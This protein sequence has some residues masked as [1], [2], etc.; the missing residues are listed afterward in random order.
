MQNASDQL[1]QFTNNLD[2]VGMTAKQATATKQA[3]EG[4]TALQTDASASKAL[5]D[6]IMNSISGTDATIS[7]KLSNLNVISIPMDANLSFNSGFDNGQAIATYNGNQLYLAVYGNCRQAVK[8]DCNDASLQR[9]VTAYLMA[10]EQDCNTVQN[11]LAQ[12]KKQLAAGIRQSAAMLDLARVQNHQDLNS[13]DAAACL[14]NVTAAITD[15]AACGA[16][17][18]KCLDNGQFIDVTTGKPFTGVVNFY[19]LAQQL[20]F[21]TTTDVANQKLSQIPANKTFVANFVKRMKPFAADA[22]TKC[23]DI[24]DQVW[25]DYLDKAM[26]SIFY[27][28]QDKV[29]EI[30]SGCMDFVAACYTQG[31]Q[32]LSAAAQSL[33]T[34]AISAQPGMIV[35]TAEMCKNYIAACDK[36]FQGT[37]ADGVVAAY[38]AN[39]KN[40]DLNDAC[41]AI[42]QKCFTDF[43][44]SDFSN[45]YTP[46]SGL[47]TK[48]GTAWDWF[49]FDA[50]EYG[51]NGWQLQTTGISQ[52][53]QQLLADSACNP[54]AQDVFGGFT[55]YI[56]T[57]GTFIY[58]SGA[59]SGD[60]TTWTSSHKTIAYTGVASETYY[61]TLNMLQNGC[62]NLQGKFVVRQ[63]SAMVDRYNI[64]PDAD[65]ICTVHFD[66][67]GYPYITL[68]PAYQIGA[69]TG[70]TPG[71]ENMCP[72]NY[73]ADVDTKSWGACLCWENGGRRSID[74]TQ[75]SCVP[76]TWDASKVSRYIIPSTNTDIS[77]ANKVCPAKSDNE[78]NNRANATNCDPADRAALMYNGQDTFRAIPNASLN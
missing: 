41:R 19:Q 46:N 22:L 13:A 14:D 20:V 2:V 68:V 34:D 61:K 37:M 15:E 9:A 63:D 44:S 28:Q 67:T 53:A 18:H 39:Q 64:Q 38:V 32:S 24:A 33:I 57:D 71:V 16:N 4:E 10:V 56:N 3:S 76:G 66:T 36:M 8:P 48:A 43:G 11:A 47:V 26:L 72:Q 23:T 74:G 70:G 5:L 65:D 35:A 58:G 69:G 31:T 78:A 62:N 60:W 7:G 21:D 40:K 45:F 59:P 54:I 1:T 75:V 27:A 77:I 12:T 52:C 49:T 25:A 55:K 73:A 42:A 50:W 30:K 51:A 6:A 29:N 17:Y